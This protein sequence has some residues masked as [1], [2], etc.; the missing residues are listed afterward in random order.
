MDLADKDTFTSS[1]PMIIFYKKTK[2]DD[3]EE[4]YKSEVIDNE[5]NPIWKPFEI[6]VK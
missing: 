2:T 3:W 4:V 5:V 6:G 1:D